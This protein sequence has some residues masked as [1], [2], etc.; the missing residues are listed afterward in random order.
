MNKDLKKIILVLGI[1]V[2]FLFSLSYLI[3]NLNLDK[4]SQE[5]NEILRNEEFDNQENETREFQGNAEN[6]FNLINKSRYE[7]GLPPFIYNEKLALSA[8]EKA[9]DMEEKQYF[10]HISPEG[11]QPWFFA[12]KNDYKYK[13]FGE[14]LAEGF[15]SAETVHESFMNSSGHRDNILSEEFEEVGIAIF[16]FEQNDLKSFLIVQHFG[17]HL[18]PEEFLVVTCSTKIRDHCRDAE[19][20]KS[21]I[22]KVIEE[23]EKLLKELE[24]PESENPLLEITQKNIEKLK[25]IQSELKNYTDQCDD[26]INKC[27]EWE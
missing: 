4:K 10:E 5:S 27:E 14:N 9:Q 13:N 20:K 24:K 19:I 26:F 25:E 12:E 18:E 6:I 22:K 17:T 2:L 11:L 23:Q 15:F 8:E 3:K 1:I 16:G 21:E 7:Y